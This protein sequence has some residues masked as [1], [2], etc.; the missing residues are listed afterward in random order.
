MG[1]DNMNL[2]EKAKKN[3]RAIDAQWIRENESNEMFNSNGLKYMDIDS[4]IL[5][6]D[7]Y[8][9][10]NNMDVDENSSSNFDG[11][12]DDILGTINSAIDDLDSEN[13][14]SHGRSR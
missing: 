7:Q 2:L 4:D 14:V 3:G 6:S 10:D 12:A 11:F 13:E 5:L 8:S 1:I 9:S